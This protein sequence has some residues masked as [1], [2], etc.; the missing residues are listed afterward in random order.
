MSKPR[1]FISST[2]YD[3]KHIRSSIEAF[4]NNIGYDA[5]LSEKGRIAYDPDIALDESCYRDAS[6]SD[7]FVMIIG[8]RYGAPSSSEHNHGNNG[9]YDRY[10]SITKKEFDAAYDIG[11][12]VY[13]LVDKAVFSEFDTYKKNRNNDSIV[14][15]HVDSINVFRLLEIILSKQRNNPIYHFEKSTEIESWLK[16]QWA[17]LFQ[18]LLRNRSNQK[19][20]LS[21]TENINKLSTLNSSL[22]RYIEELVYK[23]SPE[24][25]QARSV[26]EAE[27]K[28]IKDEE[29]MDVFLKNQSI[30]EMLLITNST[31]EDM[32]NI[33]RSSKSFAGLAKQLHELHDKN[34]SKH[35]MDSE[36]R[37]IEKWIKNEH[38]AEDIN[39][40][41][42][43]LELPN[44]KFKL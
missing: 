14:Y 23:L 2:F 20:L 29:M 11:V 39:A 40:A 6:L 31:P 34:K 42:A 19:P 30:K 26:I 43:T 25:S 33:F 35:L 17:G 10:E 9:F 5:V 18:E 44:L 8:G 7:I 22:K 12:P 28:R 32:L 16:K 1:I 21:L 13:I 36:V 27:N 15:A 24:P 41:R 37:M 4:I 38:F 3:L